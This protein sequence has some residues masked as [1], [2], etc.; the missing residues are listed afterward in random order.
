MALCLC[1][2]SPTFLEC[3][4]ILE[5]I[6]KESL[7]SIF[8]EL[9]VDLLSNLGKGSITHEE[10][11]TLYNNKA[12]KKIV[13]VRDLKLQ[14]F[15]EE[16]RNLLHLA[17]DCGVEMIDIEYEAPVEYRQALVTHAKKRGVDVVVSYHNYDT[18]PS[19]KALQEIVSNCYKFGGNIAKVATTAKTVQDSARVLG[20][21]D[22]DNRIVALTM[23]PL[24]QITRVAALKL[25]A[26]FTFVSKSE[27]EATAPGQ[28][29]LDQM[30]SVLGSLTAGL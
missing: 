2:S 11:T 23:G 27:A 30:R 7:L 12:L 24:G 26:P 5:E 19:L 8:V 21:Y 4:S 10:L 25:G 15:T 18:T 1:L 6:K 28:L 9:R 29:S 20:L 22:T 16:R 14:G 13:T 17:I 3:N